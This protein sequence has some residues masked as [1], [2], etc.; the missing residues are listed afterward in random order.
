MNNITTLQGRGKKLNQVTFKH[1]ILPI[2]P[3][4]KTTITIINM[5]FHLVCFS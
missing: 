1:T 2:Y 3:K 5:E 4:L